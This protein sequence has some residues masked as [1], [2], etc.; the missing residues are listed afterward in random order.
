MKTIC[1]DKTGTLTQNKME[2]S[3]IY[4]FSKSKITD[5]TSDLSGNTLIA[6]LFASCNSVELIND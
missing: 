3:N 5:I 6:N 1:F 2:V 4:A